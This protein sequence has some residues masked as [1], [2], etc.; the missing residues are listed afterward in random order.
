L[1][2]FAKTVARSGKEM[3]KENEDGF[4]DQ[5]QPKKDLRFIYV[6]RHFNH[7]G[8]LILKSLINFNIKPIAVILKKEKNPYLHPIIRPFEIGRAHV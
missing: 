8:Y 6:T 1:N 2:R 3:S 5:I 7:S 4:Q